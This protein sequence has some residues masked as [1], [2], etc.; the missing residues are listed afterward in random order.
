MKNELC[1]HGILGQKWGIRRYQNDDGTLTEAGRKRYQSGN[2]HK[3]YQN[4]LNDLDTAMALNGRDAAKTLEEADRLALLKNKKLSTRIK[5]GLLKGTP[6]T[7]KG[8]QDREDIDWQ[9]IEAYSKLVDIG[10]RETNEILRNMSKQNMGLYSKRVVKASLLGK[11][12]Y[13]SLKGTAGESNGK[14]VLTKEVYGPED[15]YSRDNT[16]KVE[17][18]GNKYKVSKRPHGKYRSL[19]GD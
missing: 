9:K 10:K 12:Y 13:D 18:M 7:K 3:N 11:Q 14:Y 5:S 19:R 1:H 15:E 16:Y 2:L 17:V 4:R 8:I 6:I